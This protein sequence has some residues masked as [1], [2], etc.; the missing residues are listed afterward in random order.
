MRKAESL[1]PLSPIITADLAE[2]LVLVHSYEESIRQNRK[3]IEI[4]PNFAL[5]HN[6]PAQAY[7]QRHMNDEAVAELQK[8][9]QLSGGPTVMANRARAYAASGMRGEAV[10]LLDDLKKGS[11]LVSS[12]A[13]EIAVI[14]AALGDGDQAMNW[15][16]ESYEEIKSGCPPATG[17]RSPPLRSAVARRIGLNLLSAPNNEGPAAL[18]GER[19]S[20]QIQ[21]WS[22]ET[23]CPIGT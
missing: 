21:H 19:I 12:L 20:I 8:A 11:S 4:D 22:R 1:D 14:Y 2:L 5:A 13:P 17:L 6:R 10:R 15:L 9:A 18:G 3:T 7:L 23:V 16:E